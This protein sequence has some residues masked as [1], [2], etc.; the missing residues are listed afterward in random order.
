MKYYIIKCK[1]YLLE[2]VI[3]T[4][5]MAMPKGQGT[6]KLLVK[7]ILQQKEKNYYELWVY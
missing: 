7:I 6:W 5:K 3:P 1:I 4:L 2:T